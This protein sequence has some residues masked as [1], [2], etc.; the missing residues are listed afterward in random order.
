VLQGVIILLAHNRP[1]V[2]TL[3]TLEDQVI[4]VTRLLIPIVGQP[5]QWSADALNTGLTDDDRRKVLAILPRVAI[6]AWSSRLRDDRGASTSPIAETKRLL[7][8]AGLPSD[9]VNE[10]VRPPWNITSPALIRFLPKMENYGQRVVGGH[11]FAVAEL[12]DTLTAKKQ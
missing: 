11:Q 9:L 4:A 12:I 10:L 1:L 8:G 2:S 6:C 7:E 5:S 3:N